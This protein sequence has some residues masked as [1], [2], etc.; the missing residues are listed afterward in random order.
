MSHKNTKP[1][2]NEKHAE[3]NAKRE[4]GSPQLIRYG[5]VRDLTQNGGGSGVEQTGQSCYPTPTSP[6]KLCS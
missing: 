4:Y 6:E 3:T 2:L 1:G 5:A